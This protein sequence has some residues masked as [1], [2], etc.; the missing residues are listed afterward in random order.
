MKFVGEIKI[1]VYVNLNVV[2]NT[3]IVLL[4]RLRRGSNVRLVT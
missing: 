2:R 4:T 3:C 1:V